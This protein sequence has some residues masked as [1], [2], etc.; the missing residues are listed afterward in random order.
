M[1]F[2][3]FFYKFKEKLNWKDYDKADVGE[4]NPVLPGDEEVNYDRENLRII[5]F[6]LNFI[7][8]EDY[9]IQKNEALLN[10]VA[11]NMRAYVYEGEPLFDWSNSS[12]AQKK[13][14]L[15]SNGFV[16]TEVFRIKH[17]EDREVPD[18]NFP[19]EMPKTKI[20]KGLLT[21]AIDSLINGGN[22]IELERLVVFGNEKCNST[23]C[24][25]PS[26]ANNKLVVRIFEQSES[27]N[28]EIQGGFDLYTTESYPFLVYNPNSDQRIR[29]E[30]Y[31][32]EPAIAKVYGLYYEPDG[33]FEKM[34]LTFYNNGILAKGYAFVVKNIWKLTTPFKRF[35]FTSNIP[36]I[37]NWSSSL[38][39]AVMNGSQ[40]VEPNPNK[41][42]LPEALKGTCIT[43][44]TTITI[45]D[46]EVKIVDRSNPNNS[47]TLEILAI[48]GTD[49]SGI[50]TT[51]DPNNIS[52]E[53][54]IEY[55]IIE[56]KVSLSLENSCFNA[57]PTHTAVESN[58]K[59]VWSDD[60][61]IITITDNQLSIMNRND[62]YVIDY[63][64]VF[65][66][67]GLLVAENPNRPLSTTNIYYKLIL[68]W[69][70]NYDLY[71]TINGVDFSFIEKEPP[72]IVAP[73]PPPT[74]QKFEI[75]QVMDKRVQLQWNA[76]GGADFYI[77]AYK[78]GTSGN[79]I[80]YKVVEN[81]FELFEI[82]L[83]DVYSFRVKA[84][85]STGESG[86]SEIIT[87]VHNL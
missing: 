54:P 29:V 45:T 72:P 15:F 48:S 27:Y 13:Y 6:T 70:D 19:P 83:H 40:P 49:D 20:E 51:I 46:E 12:M 63:Y 28:A 64:F 69:N 39:R 23:K 37:Y 73:L 47:K 10:E 3:N 68:N 75:T 42:T 58:L 80:E 56:D 65:I 33:Q 60:A 7:E 32:V 78:M 25:N 2:M 24:D 81:Y 26:G 85:S 77:I 74:P 53:V 36:T 38:A 41:P 9:T 31:L 43:D 84:V 35:K 14:W 67:K 87:Y 1:D 50:L 17:Y 34:L 44:T 86:W 18:T 16:G 52:V 22:L 62:G 57:T 66:S 30:S 21:M 76:V 82:T 8:G 71:L 79:W 4:D 5:K 11:K 59:N 61:C 55:N